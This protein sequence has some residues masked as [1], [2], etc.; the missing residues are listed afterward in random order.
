MLA[1]QNRRKIIARK[2]DD[3]HTEDTVLGL[4]LNLM[5]QEQVVSE[6]RELVAKDIGAAA[7]QY[8]SFAEKLEQA[9]FDGNKQYRLL[10]GGPDSLSRA[11][12]IDVMVGNYDSASTDVKEQI[13]ELAV[14]PLLRDNSFYVTLAVARMT[15][16][17]VVADIIRKYPLYNPGADFYE[18]DLLRGDNLASP[19]HIQDWLDKLGHDNLFAAMAVALQHSAPLDVAI[20]IDANESLFQAAAHVVAS[21]HDVVA[22]RNIQRDA[23]LD[24]SFLLEKYQSQFNYHFAEMIRA[25]AEEARWLDAAPF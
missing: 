1:L 11:G 25:A 4:E 9:A 3:S 8:G 12:L 21:H 19:A 18:A 15:N 17:Y 22:D 6:F 24:K 2:M 20:V 10:A 16:P 7:L 13:I 23:S 5:T 14:Q